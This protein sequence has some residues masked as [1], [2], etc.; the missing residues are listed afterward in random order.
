[1]PLSLLYL[2]HNE[3]QRAS[4]RR[5]TTTGDSLNDS[6]KSPGSTKFP[7]M[8]WACMAAKFDRAGV[9][10]TERATKAVRV[11][12]VR[13]LLMGDMLVSV[14]PRTLLLNRPK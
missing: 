4:D 2:T 8:T 5:T 6:S 12:R 13:R 14:Y 7:V 10:R 11:P 3:P 1:M 9:K